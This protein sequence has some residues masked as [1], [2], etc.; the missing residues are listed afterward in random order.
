MCEGLV[1]IHTEQF[2]ARV[3]RSIHAQQLHPDGAQQQLQVLALQQ[4][5]HVGHETTHESV[6][7]GPHSEVEEHRQQLQRTDTVRLRAKTQDDARQLLLRVRPVCT[8]LYID[9]ERRELVREEGAM[10]IFVRLCG[11]GVQQEGQLAQDRLHRE[12]PRVPQA[13]GVHVRW[14]RGVAH[15][16]AAGL[17]QN[18]V[19]QNVVSEE[20]DQHHVL[21]VEALVLV[22]GQRAPRDCVR[23]ARE[24]P[25][26]FSQRRAFVAEVPWDAVD[27]CQGDI[28]E[29]HVSLG[30]VI[31]P[32]QR[33]CDGRRQ[34]R[35]EQVR[36]HVGVLRERLTVATC[37][38]QNIL[39]PLCVG[40]KPLL[41]PV[42]HHRA[43]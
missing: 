26:Q 41:V 33:H 30:V 1:C 7:D 5:Q 15:R 21:A 17:T 27:H 10:L 20:R 31:V 16:R 4:T 36:G 28:G 2:T 24:D 40:G 43:R 6:V 38:D 19:G 14:H 34:T 25:R 42:V 11:L 23:Q 13:V 3:L 32:L 12:V 9:L 37:T 35:R 29:E 18:A 39:L 22:P 8:Q